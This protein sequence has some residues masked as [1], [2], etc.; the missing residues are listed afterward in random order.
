MCIKPYFLSDTISHHAV[1][2]NWYNDVETTYST[3]NEIFSSKNDALVLNLI[4]IAVE[5][6]KFFK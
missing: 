3:K 2:N 4:N 1:L 5:S 6:I